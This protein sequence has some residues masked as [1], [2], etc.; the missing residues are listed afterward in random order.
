[1]CATHSQPTF[2]ERP[3]WK[4][5]VAWQIASRWFAPPI[6]ETMSPT[7]IPRFH[8]DLP[9]LST[10]PCK[11]RQSPLRG[12][13]HQQL[14]IGLILEDGEQVICCHSRWTLHPSWLSSN[15]SPS[16]SK[17][18]AGSDRL[19]SCPGTGGHR[20]GFVNSLKIV[21]AP[22]AT[23]AHSKACGAVDNSPKRMATAA[24]DR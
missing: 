1:M 12:H 23:L 15:T 4:G 6:A 3:H 22:G 17:A 19:N 20:A 8:R 16:N 21:N 11:C 9:M 18:S 2:V 10:V 13:L 5:A 7:T 14:R 24:S